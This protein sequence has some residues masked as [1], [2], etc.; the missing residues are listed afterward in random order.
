MKR[1]DVQT[2]GTGRVSFVQT[3][4]E[5]R[6]KF[7]KSSQNSTLPKQ[8]IASTSRTIATTPSTSAAV[9]DNR[10]KPVKSEYTMDLPEAA[11]VLRVCVA[12]PSLPAP[13]TH[14]RV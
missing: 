14:V 4:Q 5:S 12:P 1:G 6:G 7:A 8:P 3:D 11:R 13:N 2:V 9:K 10:K